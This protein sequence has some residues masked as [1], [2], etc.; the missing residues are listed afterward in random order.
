MKLN[1]KKLKELPEDTKFATFNSDNEDIILGEYLIAKLLY[2]GFTLN[3]ILE[4]A[5]E[6][7]NKKERESVKIII[8]EITINLIE[9]NPQYVK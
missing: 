2:N 6:I 3:D 8:I 1:D 4:Q 9:L 5:N 7:K